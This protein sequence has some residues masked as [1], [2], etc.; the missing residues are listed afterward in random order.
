MAHIGIVGGGIAGLHLALR[1]QGEGVPV[2]LYAEKTS[3]QHLA[4][5]LSNVVLRSA[6]T[7][8]R[9]RALGVHHWDGVAPDLVRLRLSVTGPQ[10]PRFAGVLDP[11]VH[12]V[13]MRIYWSTLLQDFI[14]RGGEVAYG[15]LTAADVD[16]LGGRHDLVIV[17]SGRGSLCTL[18]PAIPRHSPYTAPQRLVVAGLFRGITYP[19]PCGFDVCISRGNGEI[20]AFPLHSFEPG[21]TA[22]GIEII[23]GGGLD[24]LRQQHYDSDPATFN[25]LVL[26]LLRE[27]APALYQR[28]DE[29]RFAAARAEDVC[30]VAITPVVRAAYRQLSSGTF[31][32]ALGDAHALMDPLTGQGAN[33]A[34]HAAWVVADAILEARRFDEDFCRQVDGRMCEYVLPVSDACNARL[35]PPPPHAVELLRAASVHQPI[36]DAYADGF[37]HPDRFWAIVGSPERTAALLR[38]HGW[39]GTPPTARA[40]AAA[41]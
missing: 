36:A 25:A 1:L 34:S 23:R 30:H 41:G 9:E 11:P 12:V 26:R 19:D 24:A 5:R 18:F 8:A 6:P 21:L 28:V 38:D 40:D 20:L 4:A 27:H 10:G 13:D 17:A 22:L 7:R 37:Q 35:A 2:T 16:H 15:P 29:S 31:A 39:N 33:K 3:A 32:V 14:G